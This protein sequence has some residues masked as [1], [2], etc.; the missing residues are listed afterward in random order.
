MKLNVSICKH[1]LSSGIVDRL[2]IGKVSGH[3]FCCELNLWEDIMLDKSSLVQSTELPA[4]FWTH[5]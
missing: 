2:Q 3:T 5:M 4:Y 1:D